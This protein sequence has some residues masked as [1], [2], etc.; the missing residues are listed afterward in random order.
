M[1]NFNPEKAEIEFRE[2][3]PGADLS[4]KYFFKSNFTKPEIY[5]TLLVTGIIISL[6]SL[7]VSFPIALSTSI[8][9]SVL[10]VIFDI[11]MLLTRSLLIPSGG[12]FGR[13]NFSTRYQ[14]AQITLSDGTILRGSWNREKDS[15]LNSTLVVVFGGNGEQ[16]DFL[17]RLDLTGYKIKKY[18]LLHRLFC[19]YSKHNNN[20]NKI[21]KKIKELYN[22]NIDKTRA[23]ELI[24]QY[25]NGLLSLQAKDIFDRIQMNYRG[26]NN[27][28][29]LFSSHLQHVKDGIEIVA[30]AKKLG[31]KKIK[32]VGHSLGGSIAPHVKAY[33]DQEQ[34]QNPMGVYVLNTFYRLDEFLSCRIQNKIIKTISKFTLKFFLT[35]IGWNYRYT[36]AKWNELKGEKIA[37]GGGDGDFVIPP[38]IELA[39]ML[40]SHGTD[41]DQAKVSFH[42]HEDS[43][44]LAQVLH[45]EGTVKFRGSWIG[46]NT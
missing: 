17:G 39:Q 6:F 33:F 7:P 2:T 27:S 8:T 1:L 4:V 11:G 46:L 43:E 35:C 20:K 18:E 24:K 23:L 12:Y 34:N 21:I 45:P 38:S 16:A 41:Q 37:L 28:D 32:I 22:E 25:K 19:K 42:H 44:P 31:Y 5:I 40:K 26:T 30:A 29:G 14:N 3:Q 36:A 13:S 10:T 15:T 9:L